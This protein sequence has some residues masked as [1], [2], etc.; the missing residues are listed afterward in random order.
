MK[1]EKNNIKQALDRRLS[2]LSFDRAEE[3]L[4]QAALGVDQKPKTRLRPAL[5]L[6]FL[7][8]LLAGTALAIGLSYSRQYDLNKRAREALG[9]KYGLNE[10]TLGLFYE[11]SSQEDGQDVVRFVPIMPFEAQAGTYTVRF[12]D[13]RPQAS[14][15]HDGQLREAEAS[16]DLRS[17]VW[18][19][20]QLQAF[21]GGKN[22]LQAA[23]IRLE[24]EAEAKGQEWYDWTLDQRAKK[25]ELTRQ[26]MPEGEHWDID[27]L[28]KEQDLSQEEALRLAQQAVED[29]Y[30]IPQ[31]RLKEHRM[32]L[33]FRENSGTKQRYYEVLW[34]RQG[35]QTSEFQVRLSSPGGEVLR[36]LWFTG[37]SPR[38]LPAGDL[39]PY[40]E[41]VQEY[42]E[43]GAFSRLAAADKAELAKRVREAGMEALLPQTGYVVP[44]AGV[45]SQQEAQEK[46]YAIL[47]AQMQVND[48]ARALFMEDIALLNEG[49][50]V[51]WQLSLRPR[52]LP[53][54]PYHQPPLGEYE[55]RL[56]ARHGQALSCTWSLAGENAGKTYDQSSF[57]QA[58]A[59]SG[60]ML[61]W[62]LDLYDGI[63][64]VLSRYPE[65]E[66]HH[67]KVPDNAQH[68]ALMRAAGYPSAMF[69]HG[70]PKKDAL[71]EQAAMKLAR[72]ALLLEMHLSQ[73]R[74]DEIFL[75]YPEYLIDTTYLISPN[76]R[77]VWSFC[78]YHKEGTYV[79]T[80]DAFSGTL[81][82]V[83][84]DP[85]AAG[86]G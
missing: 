53:D 38:E 85:E 69:S 81:L 16:G 30:G 17:P 75:V 61:P 79:V 33:S 13:G 8:L 24:Q 34:A 21:V 7:L 47:Q 15:S 23:L 76:S 82:L 55:V 66:Q 62:F 77:D 44:G 49:S 31:E 72:Q 39:M 68:D 25:G 19:Q 14:W 35:G 22:A 67:L 20:A 71:T 46:L 50:Q 6:A 64:E 63:K 27:V 18:G 84:Y 83:R 54:W 10:Q 43:S 9:A 3:V 37:E 26:L 78:F 41:A 32:T 65:A 70:L 48:A 42:M 58:K 29:K 59:L 28:P 36:C 11:R 80:L 52:H 1:T 73:Q 4:K 60:P 12:V 56:D 86:N 51:F 2:A 74:M 45:L 5:A 57:G 40:P